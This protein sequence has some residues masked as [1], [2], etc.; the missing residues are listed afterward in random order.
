MHVC[1]VCRIMEECREE[2]GGEE[3][4]SSDEDTSTNQNSDEAEVPPI[5]EEEYHRM[6]RVHHK[7]QIRKKVK[8]IR[9][10]GEGP[11]VMMLVVL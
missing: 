9:L 4:M 1:G 8:N 10:W 2:W 6:L 3:V 11:Q 7:R 5:S